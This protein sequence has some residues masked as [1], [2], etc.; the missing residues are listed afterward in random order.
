V[1]GFMT[2]FEKQKDEFYKKVEQLH[3]TIAKT[4][5]E[6]G[7]ETRDYSGG[8]GLEDIGG[9]KFLSCHFCLKVVADKSIR[10][11]SRYKW[12]DDHK[13][14]SNRL[15]LT[16]PWRRFCPACKRLY[17]DHGEV[18]LAFCPHDTT[19]LMPLSSLEKKRL[20]DNKSS[21]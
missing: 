8:R 9:K 5:K 1:E 3:I 10:G 13:A 14:P 17:V 4:C 7:L 11:D 20:D 16:L 18:P 2:P 6:L 21:I 15:A 12:R 19:L